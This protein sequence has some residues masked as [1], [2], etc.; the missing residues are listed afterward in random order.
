M[1]CESSPG[2]YVLASKDLQFCDPYRQMG[3]SFYDEYEPKFKLG[4]PIAEDPEFTAYMAGHDAIRHSTLEFSQA[5]VPVYKNTPAMHTIVAADTHPLYVEDDDSIHSFNYADFARVKRPNSSSAAHRSRNATVVHNPV[6]STENDKTLRKAVILKDDLHEQGKPVELAVPILPLGTGHSFLP[7]FPID[8]VGRKLDEALYWIETDHCEEDLVRAA[9]VL[10]SGRHNMTN[11][12]ETVLPFHETTEIDISP[13]R[14][15]GFQLDVTETLFHLEPSHVPKRNTT[16]VIK[17]PPKDCHPLEECRELWCATCGVPDGN[18]AHLVVSDLCVQRSYNRGAL[19]WSR[20][21]ERVVAAAAAH[22]LN[23][24][25]Q[26]FVLKV[27]QLGSRVID[28]VLAMLFNVYGSMKMVKPK[29]SRN[30]NGEVFFVFTSLR[31]DEVYRLKALRYLWKAVRHVD[32]FKAMAMPTKKSLPLLSNKHFINA[33]KDLLLNQIRW[34]DYATKF[35]AFAISLPHFRIPSRG[36]H[37]L[38]NDRT[39]AFTCPLLEECNCFGKMSMC[40]RCTDWFGVQLLMVT[41][42]CDDVAKRVLVA[43]RSVKTKSQFKAKLE[44]MAI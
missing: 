37:L 28:I 10:G 15:G 26:D 25:A 39:T 42:K 3:M 40:S 23:L 41:T 24:E 20:D 18:G 1:L 36:N 4:E 17:L 8:R 6:N 12:I 35:L 30:L 27:P 44:S 33:R 38:T 32:G 9:V 16:E 21:N 5:A 29:A 14:T 19:D 34:L 2:P 7:D 13:P 22:A 11:R 43:A 31:V